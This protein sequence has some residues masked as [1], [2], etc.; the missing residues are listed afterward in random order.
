MKSAILFLAGHELK[1]YPLPAV[2]SGL[3]FAIMGLMTGGMHLGYGE[4]Q[5]AISK[6]VRVVQSTSNDWIILCIVSSLGFV[7]TKDYFSYYR[8][9]TFSRRLAFYRKLPIGGREIVA[10]RYLVLGA[11]L[12]AMSVCYYTPLYA[13]LRAES[14]LTPGEGAGVF[15]TWFSCS[16]LAGSIYIYLELGYTG[17]Q[18]LKMSFVLILVFLA[19]LIVMAVLNVHIVEGTLELVKRYG[20]FPPVI[21]FLMALA[22]A[23]GMAKVTLRRLAS[24][25][26]V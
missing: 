15:L 9:D 1:R 5:E 3:F 10:A 24:R 20:A 8:T 25:D 17:K 18:Y 21:S 2:L 12:I 11:S 7:Y 6:A 4:S 14:V 26:L 23:Y 19:F 16:I 22:G 13:L